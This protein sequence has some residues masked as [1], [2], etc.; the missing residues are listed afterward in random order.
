[1]NTADLKIDQGKWKSRNTEFSPKGYV[2]DVAYASK[3]PKNT[4]GAVFIKSKDQWYIFTKDKDLLNITD[5]DYN[6]IGLFYFGPKITLN[7]FKEKIKEA[8]RDRNHI[9]CDVG[10]VN[11]PFGSSFPGICKYIGDC[12]QRINYHRNNSKRSY[13][14]SLVALTGPNNFE[15]SKGILIEPNNKTISRD[16]LYQGDLTDNQIILLLKKL[17][18]QGYVKN[19]GT[20]DFDLEKLDD[21]TIEFDLK[22]PIIDQWKTYKL[23]FKSNHLDLCL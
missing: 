5:L 16:I 10:P 23:D 2:Y 19:K 3:A 21:I 12:A 18:E 14:I 7:G 17:E 11:D 15:Q 20:K 9:L 13:G 1:M 6:G 8:I 4:K 22:N